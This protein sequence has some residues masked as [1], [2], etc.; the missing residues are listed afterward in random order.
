LS[1]GLR[2]HSS[3]PDQRPAGIIS[4]PGALFFR[5]LLIS[6]NARCALPCPPALPHRARMVSWLDVSA[7]DPHIAYTANGSQTAFTV[8]FLFFANSDLKVYLN[9]VLQAITTNYTVAGAL[10]ESGGT[11]TFLVAPANGVTVLIVRD[12]PL[13]LTTHVPPSGPLDILSLNFQFSRLVAMIQQVEDVFGVAVALGNNSALAS[14]VVNDSSVSGASVKDAL[15]RVAPVFNVKAFGA[16]GDGT[17]ND[18]AAIQAACNACAVAGGGTV[19]FPPTGAAYVCSNITTGNGVILA[20]DGSR[21]FPGETATVAQWTATGSWIRSADTV[22]P[23][24]NLV[25]HGSGTIGL[26]FIRTQVIPGGGAYTPT[27]FP[28]EIKV[29]ATFFT[30]NNILTVGT[31][32]DIWIAYT[33]GSGGGS[34]SHLTNI[35]SGALIRGIK[36]DNVNDTMYL[37]NLKHRGLFYESTASLVT[38]RMANT[39][40]WDCGYCD[41]PQVDGLEFFHCHTGMLF[42]DQTCLGNTHSLFNAQF[43]GVSFNL[44]KYAMRPAAGDTHVQVRFTNVL[45]QG[46]TPSGLSDQLF[47]LTS[48]NVEV[49]F[50]SLFVPN[51]GGRV[52]ELGNGA[53]GH[54]SIADF[55]VLNY[56]SIDTTASC[57]L[58]NAGSRVRLGDWSISTAASTGAKFTGTG[59]FDFGA[60]QRVK[61]ITSSPYTVLASDNGALLVFNS[62][63]A[64]AVTLPQAIGNFGVGFYVDVENQGAGLVTITPT[65]STIGGS[66]SLAVPQPQGGRIVSDG[67]NYRVQRGMGPLY[68]AGSWTPAITFGGGA[69]GLTYTSQA[70]TYT[71]IGNVV[72]VTFDIRLSAKGTSTGNVN[73]TGLPF[74]V[75]SLNGAGSLG[76]YRN[77]ATITGA[78]SVVPNAATAIATME[79]G[80]AAGGTNLTEVH[81]TNTS[82]IAGTVVYLLN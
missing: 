17:T 64:I 20:G 28:Y 58:A 45:A 80:G 33:T 73:I 69:T 39:I 67:A 42:T 3:S 11:V 59:I 8:P 75:G 23:T 70:G 18:S 54:V 30:I 31:T 34:Y 19:W 24:I 46:D 53:G 22:N 5:P 49:N 63:S 7:T 21:V 74:T 52:F 60:G 47:L 14:G 57:F 9:G 66:S 36:F 77:M 61:E 81:F 29:T 1:V 37:A 26:N 76:Q 27:T 62:G 41:N 10:N 68:A 25:G 40:G 43:G 48:D 65:T 50:G 55:H 15:N 4:R 71:R 72:T 35:F 56:G 13:A 6:D 38:Y 2:L 51:A 79:Q 44:V 32:H 82:I 12:L 78:I 16:V